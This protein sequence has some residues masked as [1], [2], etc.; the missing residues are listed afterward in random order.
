LEPLIPDPLKEKAAE[1]DPGEITETFSTPS[2]GYCVAER[3][4]KTFPSATLP[5]RP[6]TVASSDGSRKGFLAAYSKPWQK[7]LKSVDM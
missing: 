3:P 5:T 1:A 4:G 2:C 7:T 6:A